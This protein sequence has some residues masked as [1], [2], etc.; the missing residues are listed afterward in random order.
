MHR[1]FTNWAIKE[2][3]HTTKQTIC[4]PPNLSSKGFPD[5]APLA[6]NSHLLPRCPSISITSPLQRSSSLRLLSPAC[7]KFL[8]LTFITRVTGGIFAAHNSVPCYIFSGAETTHTFIHCFSWRKTNTI[9]YHLYV[10]SK[11]CHTWPCLRNRNRL[12]DIETDLWLPSGKGGGGG[13]DWELGISRCRLLPVER[14][15]IKVLV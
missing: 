11:L 2:A 15:N 10:E 3:L 6:C 5:I 12:R 1:F 8:W 13:M 14:I 7:C 4:S 9:W